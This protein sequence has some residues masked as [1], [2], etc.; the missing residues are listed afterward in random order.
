[1]FQSDMGEGIAFKNLLMILPFSME[2]T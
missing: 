1:V 2:E